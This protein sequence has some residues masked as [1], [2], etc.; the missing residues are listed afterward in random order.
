MTKFFF[1]NGLFSKTILDIELRSFALSS[2]PTWLCSVPGPVAIQGVHFLDFFFDFFA[3]YLNGSE[4]FLQTPL[5]P[6][7]M[8]GAHD[9]CIV[10]VVY[11]S[12]L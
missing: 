7:G 9:G 10:V 11:L 3:S 2:P 12:D 1:S 4:L 8:I 5:F 6:V